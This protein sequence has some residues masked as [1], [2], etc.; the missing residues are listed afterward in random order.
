MARPTATTTPAA[1]PDPS[2]APATP[3]E[4]PAEPT[5]TTGVQRPC[6][7]SMSA[8]DEEPHRAC[9]VQ[10]VG[11]DARYRYCGPHLR[12]VESAGGAVYR[13]GQR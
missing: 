1:A 11:G 3:L 2:P 12:Q 5:E 8:P 4:R 9:G 10:S 6:E 13:D 7:M